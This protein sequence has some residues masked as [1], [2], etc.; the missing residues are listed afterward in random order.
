[1]SSPYVLII[2]LSGYGFAIPFESKQACETAAQKLRDNSFSRTATCV[3]TGNP[4]PAFQIKN[5]VHYPRRIRR[6]IWRRTN[7]WRSS[8]YRQQLEW[9]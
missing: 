1:M 5:Y 3:E 4:V 9:R 8:R 2:L 7:D 6:K